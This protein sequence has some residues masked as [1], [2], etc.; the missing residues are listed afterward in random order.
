MFNEMA[1]AVGEWQGF[2]IPVPDLPV[3]L[4]D[5]HP[6]KENYRRI[7]EEVSGVEFEIVCGGP[8]IDDTE[9]MVN[10]WF[11][12]SL[13][14]TIQIYR[15]SK[16]TFHLKIPRSPDGS[17]QRLDL[18]L[19][20]VG[21]ADG[22]DLDAEYKARELLKGMIN[23]RQWHQYDL[24]G[25]FLESSQKSGLFYLFRRLRP[26]VCMTSGQ[27]WGKHPDSMRVLAVLCMHPIGY[28]NK[29][30][31]GCL[32]PT[33]DV[34]AHLTHMRGDEANYWRIANQHEPASPEAGI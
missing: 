24:T 26:T 32:C 2:P 11:S 17:M 23:E 21:A 5:R 28:Y 18:W 33:D 8:D 10:Q 4:H 7:D 20:T 19:N 31:G 6:L 1:E 29:S 15:N 9:Y 30:W 12:W 34:V 22:W 13:N 16:G 14:C 25:A 27:R 3:I